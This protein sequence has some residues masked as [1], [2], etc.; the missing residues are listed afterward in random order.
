MKANSNSKNREHPN[1]KS[2]IPNVSYSYLKVTHVRLKLKKLGEATA[3][4][5]IDIGLEK[6]DESM[7]LV[8]PFNALT[9][10]RAG[11]FGAGLI[12]NA[13]T[14]KGSEY[15]ET[16]YIA[17]EPL[18]IRSIASSFGVI[19]DAQSAPTKAMIEM[20]LRRNHGQPTFPIGG[21]AVPGMPLTQGL[22]QFS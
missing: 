15:T 20:R 2:Y 19:P 9:L 18:L 10:G 5:L 8:K 12:L 13:L 17:A 11:M 3:V 7:G 16:L 21:R 22:A 6:L 14:D 1:K 4:G